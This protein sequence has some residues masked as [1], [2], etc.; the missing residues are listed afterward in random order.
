M[1]QVS[2]KAWGPFACFT[3]SDARLDRVSYDVPT[4]AACRGVLEAIYCKPVEFWYEIREI[5]VLNPIRQIV[6]RKNEIS[7]KTESKKSAKPINVSDD[8]TRTQRA[9]A[10]LRDVAYIIT[11]NIHVRDDFLPGH[12]IQ[13]KEA[14]I[15]REFEKR[16]NGGKCFAQPY[17]GLKE[18]L[19]YY[20]MPHGNETPINVT[21]D[22]GIML[23]DIFD[24]ENTEVLDTRKK[25]RNITTE[26]TYFHP[27]M[28]NG[29]VEVPEYSSEEIFK[30][31]EE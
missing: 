23:Y 22:L 25:T 7:K 10:Y 24:P 21:K 4:P 13:E 31:Q 15:R 9:T 27:R 1:I 20:E 26:I 11:A 29:I 16:V 3:R 8:S 18:C 28:V 30:A 5:K 6:V 19:C 17:F 2:I 12:L 14:K